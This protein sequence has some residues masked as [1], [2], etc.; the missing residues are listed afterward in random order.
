M[1]KVDFLDISIISHIRIDNPDRLDNFVIRNEF[2]KEH[3]INL[4]FVHVE[5]G[6]ISKCGDAITKDDIHRLTNNTGEYRKN[7]SYNIGE[8]LT[9]RKYLLFLDVDCVLDPNIIKALAESYADTAVVY[10]YKSVLYS[11]KKF[12][13][14]FQDENQLKILTSSHATDHGRMFTDSCGG[15]ILM[16]RDMFVKTGGFNPNFSGWG[17]ED[18]E[19]RDR[20]LK[21]GTRI[22]R[23]SENITMLHLYHGYHSFVRNK[24]ALTIETRKNSQEYKKVL[25][26]NK[27]QCV[28]HMKK[29]GIYE[30]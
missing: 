24:Q 28:E 4:E 29:W 20:C 18:S 6:D 16:S 10:P 19:Y 13:K 9:K 30:D 26:M 7:G 25:G 15:A 5:D 12:A 1:N 2:Y 23:P 22:V 27:E 17:Y 3:C 8:T 21:L 11:T 14:R